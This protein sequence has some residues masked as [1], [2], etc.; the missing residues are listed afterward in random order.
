MMIKHQVELVDITSKECPLHSTRLDGALTKDE[1][2]PYSENDYFDEAQTQ[3]ICLCDEDSIE[4][5]CL[6]Y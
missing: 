3:Q 6:S 5:E 1:P 4:K 2:T